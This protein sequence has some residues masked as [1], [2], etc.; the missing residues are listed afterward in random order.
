[1]AEIER[2]HEQLGSPLFGKPLN[3]FVNATKFVSELVKHTIKDCY[4]TLYLKCL[5]LTQ[6]FAI[7]RLV[8]V[9]AVLLKRN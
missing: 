6:T 4:G 5:W 2:A 3:L 1:M 7:S 8:L 9:V